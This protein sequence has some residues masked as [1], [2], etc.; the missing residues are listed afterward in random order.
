MSWAET[1]YAG[2][3]RALAARGRLAR[4]ERQSTLADLA[5]EAHGPMIGARRSYGDACLN[6]GGAALLS[7]RLDRALDFDPDA[8]EITVEA[9]MPLGRLA[10]LTAP[11]GFLPAVMPGTGHATVGGAIAMDVHGKNHHHAGSFGQHVAA[12]T[13]MTRDGPR[14]LGPGDP[15]FAATLGGLGQ[16]GPIATARLR[17]V[18][19]RGDVMVVTERRVADWDAHLAALSDGAAPYSVGW[20]DATA[21]GAALGRGIVE[22]AE[23][24]AGLTP[25]RKPPRRVPVDAP[26]AALSPPVVRLFNAAY[27]ARV[28]RT[29]RT[30]VRPIG[31]FF[32]PLD[33]IADWN[34]LYGKAGFHQFQCVVP[35]GADGA[36]RAMLER[37]AKSGLASPLAVLKRMGPGRAGAMSFPMAGWTLACDFRAGPEAEA[38]I[39]ALYDETARAG[40][41]LYFAK[42]SLATPGIAHEMY[43]ERADWAETVNAFDPSHAYATDLVRRLEL[44]A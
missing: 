17:L 1:A 23:T 30:V 38:L 41:R 39:A 25:T 18:A 5:R 12:L 44:R 20:I 36:L 33:R 15:L 40:G 29:G 31:D 28:P 6:D 11:H 13:L 4:P 14:D 2:W 34:R 19:I 42:D 43:P 8:A 22:T 27:F 26:R 35:T 37:I 24:G 9:G 32:N 7:D 10:R 21:T 16:T 3:G